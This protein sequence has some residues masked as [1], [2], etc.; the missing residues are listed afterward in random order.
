MSTE[1]YLGWFPEKTVP[2][3]IG[4]LEH[5]HQCGADVETAEQPF[6]ETDMVNLL[7]SD[8]FG[9]VTIPY[10]TPANPH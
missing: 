7:Q 4:S 3:A 2:H 8:K 1:H 5:E 9:L 10:L 6:G